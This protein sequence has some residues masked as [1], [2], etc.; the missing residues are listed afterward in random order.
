MRASAT[1]ARAAGSC[2][3]AIQA[4][5]VVSWVSRVGHRSC[6]PGKRVR[7]V[8]RDGTVLIDRFVEGRSRDIVLERAG[9][10]PHDQIGS[11]MI[12]KGPQGK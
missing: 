4:P 7:V 3:R 11:F 8:L 5:S 9:R 10:V 6:H 12:Y 2:E 1:A